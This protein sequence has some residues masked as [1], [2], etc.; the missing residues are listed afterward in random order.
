V[1]VLVFRL[2]LFLSSYAPLFLVLAYLNR[3]TPAAWLILGGV[4]LVSVTGLVLV[5]RSL[6]NNGPQIKVKRATP[7]DGDVM[8]YVT[9]YLLPFLDVDLS[10]TDQVIV[11]LVFLAVL[12]TVYVNSSMLFVN[13]LLSLARFHTFDV[14]DENDDVYSVITRRND[15]ARD[16]VLTPHQ[17]SRYVRVEL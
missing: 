2:L 14:T 9:G 3:S 15:F 4:V 16:T 11:S 17:V 1:P 8:A 13:P 7:K 5:F 6:S 10:D 12:G